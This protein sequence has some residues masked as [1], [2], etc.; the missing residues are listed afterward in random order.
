MRT[1]ML[2]VFRQIPKSRNQKNN[3]TKNLLSFKWQSASESNDG[4][5]LK[6]D[7]ERVDQSLRRGYNVHQKNINL[8]KLVSFRIYLFIFGGFSNLEAW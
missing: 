4:A 2:L 3:K 8:F 1:I 7:E 6:S 5:A